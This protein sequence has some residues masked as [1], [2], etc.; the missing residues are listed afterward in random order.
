M[1][2]LSGSRTHDNLATA[3]ARESQTRQR[4]LWFAQVADI[5]G[6]PDA[7]ALFRSIA[8]GETG[9]VHGLLEHLAAVGDPLTGEPIGETDENLRAAIAGETSDATEHHPGWAATARAEG[10]D[11]IADWFDTLARAE[12]AQ[13]DRFRAGLDALG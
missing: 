3:F 8:D 4:Y 10:F 5:D 6:Q 2:E 9:H 12:L 7:A 1:P 13:A 11:D